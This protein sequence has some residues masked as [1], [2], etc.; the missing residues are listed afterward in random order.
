[1]FTL[2]GLTLQVFAALS[3]TYAAPVA[4]WL[5]PCVGWGLMVLLRVNLASHCVHLPLLLC[6]A[7]TCRA[8]SCC[9]ELRLPRPPAQRCMVGLL[10]GGQY[11]LAAQLSAQGA[12]HSHVSSWETA[13]GTVQW[14]D[15]SWRDVFQQGSSTT[16]PHNRSWSTREGM[17]PRFS[18]TLQQEHFKRST[19]I[20]RQQQH[21]HHHLCPPREYSATC[22]CCC[23][24]CC[25]SLLQLGWRSSRQHAL[26]G[27]WQVPPP[28]SFA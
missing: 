20:P 11:P 26:P 19:H 5:R 15:S 8:V 9:A 16:S 1:M 10:L 14:P 7:M 4:Q 18:M 13:A 28:R 21:H 23:C 24:C 25:R 3:T 17:H 27:A 22:S 12:S 2:A 6:C